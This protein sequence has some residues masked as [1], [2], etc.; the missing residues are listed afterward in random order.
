LP[1]DGVPRAGV[2]K[3]GLVANTA[4]PEPV[5][6]VKAPARLAEVKEPKEVALPTEV[7]APVRLAL[8]TTVVALPTEVTPPVRLA[9]VTTVV[10]LPTEVTPPVRLALV[11]T[12]A[13]F[14]PIESPAAVPVILVPTRVVGVP[15]FGAVS[16]LLVKV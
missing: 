15:K 8:V 9:L 5:S 12:V 3:A 2:T 10:A 16:V 7:I 13:A 1:E 11:V 14:P 4:L 6:S